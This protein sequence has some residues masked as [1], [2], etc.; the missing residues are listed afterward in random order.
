MSAMNN[1]LPLLLA[2]A[3]SKE[4]IILP[5]IVSSCLFDET[6]ISQFQAVNPPSQPLKALKED[7]QEKVFTEVAQAVKKVLESCTGA[8]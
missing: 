3:K 8:A 6:E 4:I 1:E 7:G 2:S 5:I